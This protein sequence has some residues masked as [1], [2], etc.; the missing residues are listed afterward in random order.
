MARVLF[1][2]GLAGSPLARALFIFGVVALHLTVAKVLFTFGLGGFT[3]GEGFVYVRCGC[4]T[5]S[6]SFI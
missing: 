1:T 2:F 5:F 4:I 6:W 3:F